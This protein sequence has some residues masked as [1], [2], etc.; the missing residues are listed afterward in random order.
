MAY[1]IFPHA[2]FID[3]KA[4]LV[5]N[6]GRNR[7]LPLQKFR[8]RHYK[9]EIMNEGLQV[10]RNHPM[11]KCRKAIDKFS[12]R[13]PLDTFNLHLHPDL[14]PVPED[15]V[16]YITER[17]NEIEKESLRHFGFQDLGDGGSSEK[18]EGADVMITRHYE[19]KSPLTTIE[20]ERL[21]ARS[22]VHEVQRLFYLIL[23]EPGHLLDVD[24]DK[25][26]ETRTLSFMGG[27]DTLLRLSPLSLR[28]TPVGARGR[29]HLLTAYLS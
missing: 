2:T 19:S 25:L 27:L 3:R 22:E 8:D 6:L 13:I 4:Y 21:I 18:P 29:G 28:P 9:F 5:E 23:V 7:E 26:E 16:V 14:D 24:N 15:D 1:S 11:Q 10:R 20:L 12:W 17:K